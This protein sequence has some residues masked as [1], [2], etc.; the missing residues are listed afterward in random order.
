MEK[1]INTHGKRKKAIA[2]AALKAGKGR[3]T[4][5]RVDLENYTPELYKLKMMEPIILAGE[6]AQQVDIDVDIRGGGMSSQ[7]TAARTCIGKALVQ[8]SPKLKKVFL[9]YDRQLL[10]GDVRRKEPSKPNRH[11]KARAR[12]QK[13][14]R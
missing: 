12:R 3:V 9:E 10:V 6:V 2:R 14:Y 11:G 4:I 8:H 7:T 1:V 5:N 13:S